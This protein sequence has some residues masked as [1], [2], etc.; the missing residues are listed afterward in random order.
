MKII[1]KQGKVFC[2]SCNSYTSFIT[3]EVECTGI[4]RGEEYRYVGKQARCSIC[5]AKIDVADYCKD[6]RNRLYEE[7]SKKNGIIDKSKIQELPEKYGIG[8]RPLSLLL[9]WGE[10]TLSRYMDGLTPTKLYSDILSRIYDDPKF[11]L[12]ILEENKSKLQSEQA[13]EKSKYA[14]EQLLLELF[15]VESK[16]D[17]VAQYVLEQCGDITPLAL[18]KAL[19]YIQGFYYAFFGEFIF[20]EDCEAWLHGPTYRNAYYKY[21]GYKLNPLPEKNVQKKEY[22]FTVQEK[23]VIDCVINSICCYSGNI[24]EKFTCNEMPWLETRWE[25]IDGEH[26]EKVIGKELIGKCFTKIKDKYLMTSPIDIV[27]YSTDMFVAL[28]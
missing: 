6:N 8:K 25:V 7:Y 5:G 17:S 26:S 27:Q 9:G 20:K 13:Y 24:L 10:H 11:Y 19:Y 14:T 4:V 21:S 3:D 12:D 16:I 1:D 23:K 18:Q 22:N 28:T 15:K 2:D